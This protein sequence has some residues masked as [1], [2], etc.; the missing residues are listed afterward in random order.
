[1]AALS[2]ISCVRDFS[3]EKI[4]PLEA[5]DSLSLV[6]LSLST[7]GLPEARGM[8]GTP[9][10]NLVN[11]IDV[12][13][14]VDDKFYY[15]AVGK[16]IDEG[17]P[18]RATQEFQVKLPF[19]AYS[20]AVIAN[21]SDEVENAAP[22][23]ASINNGNI[24]REAL[25]NGIVAGEIDK[26]GG[27]PM[28]GEKDNVTISET[29]TTISSPVAL[30]RAVA[31]V[32]VSVT[33]ADFT[34]SSVRLYNRSEKG[35]V[36]PGSSSPNIPEPASKLTGPLL[37]NPDNGLTATGVEEAIY[38]F[39]SPVEANWEDNTCLVISGSYN[40]GSESFYRVD[41]LGGN[42]T[43]IPLL[44]NHRYL[45]SITSITG[46]GW[47]DEEKALANKP[48]NL[49]VGIKDEND[50]EMNHV[51]FNDHNYLS[52]DK[53]RL[54]FYKLGA[55]KSLLVT[56]DYTDGWT[57]DASDFPEW[58]T[59]EGASDGPRD[60]PATLALAV[61]E[62]PAGTRA[63]AFYITAGNLRVEITVVQIDEIEVELSITDLDGIPVTGLLF[64]VGNVND[65]PAARQFRV[66]WLPAS[67]T[68]DVSKTTVPGK[69]P[70]AHVPGTDEFS[71]SS[72]AGI[73]G[74]ETF[75]VQ[76][77]YNNSGRDRAT[78]LDFRVTS[79]GQ[80]ASRS[81][82]L[83]QEAADYAF[84][85]NND[86][87]YTLSLF[88][89]FPREPDLAGLNT[90]NIPELA[91]AISPG[92]VKT[93]VVEGSAPGLSDD[94][95][96]G[97]KNKTTL[98][99]GLV[100]VSLPGLARIPDNA[101]YTCPWLRS[102]E[103]PVATDIGENAFFQCSY[104]TSITIPTLATIGNYAFTY[105]RVLNFDNLVITGS[106]GE[107]AFARCDALTSVDASE[108]TGTIGTGA[109]LF[110]ENLTT[111][112]ISAATGI[113]EGAFSDCAKL[114]SVNIPNVVT[115]GPKAFLNCL[116][117]TSFYS[118]GITSIE[119]K[120][121][122]GC[123]GLTSVDFPGV[124]RI[125]NY[126]FRNCGLNEV[127]FG[128]KIITFGDHVFDGVDTGNASLF[129]H[130][131]EARNDNAWRGLNWGSISNYE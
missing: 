27:F 99:S 49:V 50:G 33:A 104:L 128:A 82:Y 10:E 100:N 38:T 55:K 131:E 77:P 108:L 22:A 71:A 72:H 42:G 64:G 54:D 39:E 44:R 79:G 6:T 89:S 68:L 73:D 9:A 32:D 7:P 43:Y 93:L 105:C 3:G 69:D 94:Q 123:T 65:P 110:C 84:S 67:V 40:G 74:V 112:D 12:L 28:Y 121:F 95:V 75:T 8:D 126:A 113:G 59:I 4:N 125:G 2:F 86:D 23:V 98:L 130:Q 36:A 106:I 53:I 102:L 35:R 120:T 62:N 18:G 31:R 45:V 103:A 118:P 63:H 90:G 101:F 91:G 29:N 19:G 26:T 37:Y 5:G 96:R 117:L 51:T 124:T 114:E 85:K 11:E 48:S 13:L 129:L 81:L 80:H 109:F 107:S 92:A 60:Q 87:T 57:V 16:V 34:L 14:F 116:G 47:T 115:I 46:N 127:K 20:I 30:T 56:T 70:F 61:T 78:R 15:R 76:P 41:F 58:L 25:L 52:V 97:I 66:T 119:E 24:E 83:I 1:M 111:I 88:A 17:L 122:Q 21:A